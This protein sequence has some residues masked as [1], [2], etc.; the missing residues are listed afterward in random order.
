MTL[1]GAGNAHGCQ[2][3]PYFVFPGQGLVVGR[4]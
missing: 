4:E 3:P 1:I 2:I